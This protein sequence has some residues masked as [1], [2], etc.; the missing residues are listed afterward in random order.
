MTRHTTTHE[1]GAGE[2]DQQAERV[3][4]GR[5]VRTLEREVDVRPALRG[6]RVRGRPRD[7]ARRWKD[8]R[9]CRRQCAG[10]V[11]RRRVAHPLAAV[12]RCAES[13]ASIVC[14]GAAGHGRRRRSKIGDRARR[15]RRDDQQNSCEH[16]HSGG[17]TRHIVIVRSELTARQASPARLYL[18]PPGT[19][20][21][22]DVVACPPI[23]RSQGDVDH[24]LRFA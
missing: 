7:H 19:T 4:M 9:L 24:P 5:I 3:Q 12:I 11:V 18:R 15:Q 23:S 21:V 20:R 14:L 10:Q 13:G 2:S 1:R 17:T 16:E 22:T 8:K 6:R